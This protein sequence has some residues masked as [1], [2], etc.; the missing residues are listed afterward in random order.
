MTLGRY[1]EALQ[2]LL[3]L[4]KQVPKEAPIHVNLGKI[5]RSMGNV[6]KALYHFTRAL[7]LDP[8]DTNMVKNLIDKIHSAGAGLN[9]GDINEDA[10]I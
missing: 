5:Y 4:S 1:E 3:D 8:K 7:D 6:E 9:G 10:D 2:V